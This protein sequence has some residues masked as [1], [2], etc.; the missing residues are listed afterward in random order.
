M[1]ILQVRVSQERVHV[2]F[3]H[4]HCFLEAQFLAVVRKRLSVQQI[5]C[6]VALCV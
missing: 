1:V 6:L 2:R 5:D 4:G 3:L